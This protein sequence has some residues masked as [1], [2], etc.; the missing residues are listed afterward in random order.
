M[1]DDPL[2]G[3]EMQDEIDAEKGDISQPGG[4]QQDSADAFEAV[5]VD[6]AKADIP[7]QPPPDVLDQLV[8]P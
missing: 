1:T 8:R 6:E 4:V 5:A 2:T 7:D 3:D